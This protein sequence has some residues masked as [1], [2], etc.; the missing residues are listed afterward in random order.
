MA[1]PLRTDYAGAIHHVFIRGVARSVIATDEDDYVN[2][3]SLL[4]SAIARF[5][6]E[7]HAWC[8]VANHAH[9]LITSRLGN[10]SRAMHWIGTCTAQSFNKR[11]ERVGHLYQGRFG[12]R[13]VED[14][15]YFLE[16]AR[17]IPSNPV[18]AELCDAAVD[19]PWSS[20]AA[21]VGESP[22][23]WFLD[24]ALLTTKLGSVDAYAAWV[25]EGVLATALDENGFPRPPERPSLAELMVDRSETG[26][27]VAHLR[28]GY[29]KAALARHLGV[30]QSQIRRRLAAAR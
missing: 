27:V 30:S 25:G 15:D 4:A 8:Y 7:C 17:Y 3:L 29:S 11:H 18:R 10:L 28:H 24:D 21:T 20:F 14:D 13:L 16:L 19:W 6:I 23:P 5:E 1:R 2:A 9:F 12:S 26:L 22:R